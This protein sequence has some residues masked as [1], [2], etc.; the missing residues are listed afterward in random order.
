MDEFKQTFGEHLEVLR[1]MLFRI[2]V[3]VAFISI[4]VFLYKETIFDL[5][6]APCNGDFISYRILRN[7]LSKFADKSMLFSD[8]INLIAID[9]SSQLMNHLTISLYFGL[10]IAS[11]F[12]LYEIIR[13]ISPALY[14]NEKKYAGIILGSAYS[15]FCIGLLVS[16]YILFPISCRFLIEYS[17]SSLVSTTVTLDSYTSL[18]TSLSFLLGVVFEMPV[19]CFILCKMNILDEK[20]MKDYRKYAFLLILIVSA[21]IT[22]PDVLTQVIVALPLYMLYEVS[23][24]IVRITIQR[25]N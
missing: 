7:V 8:D 21:L 9:I 12:L 20:I 16:Y 23:I 3:V 24:L 18:F 4:L 11:P 15:L 2:I 14:E 5:V 17:V 22:P 1:K 6:L 25:S 10:L 13:Y 19:L